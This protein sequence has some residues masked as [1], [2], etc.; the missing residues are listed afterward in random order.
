M[1]IKKAFQIFQTKRSKI[2][3]EE[4]YYVLQHNNVKIYSKYDFFFKSLYQQ[5][6]LDEFYDF[7]TTKKNPVIVDLGANIGFGVIYWKSKYPDSKIL[8]VEP[9]VS[10]YENLLVNIN[11]NEFHSVE[12]LNKAIWF[13]NT[14]LEFA[15][16]EMI[17]GSLILEKKLPKKYVVSTMKLSE[18]NLDEIDFLKI[19]I[20]G[21]ENY[22]LD[23]INK[24]LSRVKNVFIEYH[25]FVHL[26]QN[27]SSLLSILEKNNFRYFM[28]TENY[29]KH[30]L[31]GDSIH[32]GQDFQICIW[33]K[34]S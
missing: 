32:L 18:I 29:R 17:S 19:D 27:L 28:Q 34:R 24:I 15:A 10:V 3:Q 31:V 4:Q 9:S 16:D 22:I 8:A 30:P 14:Q 11:K 23:D 6:F 2:Y 20:E 33:G 13:E 25:S 7:N 21:A 5:I 26:D 12:T 1:N